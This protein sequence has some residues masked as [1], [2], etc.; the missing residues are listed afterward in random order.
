MCACPCSAAHPG[1]AGGCTGTASVLGGPG[2]EP[3][4][5]W[6]AAAV[7]GG[8][9]GAAAQQAVHVG[10][11]AEALK[12]DGTL[13]ASQL[14]ALEALWRSAHAAGVRAGRYGGL[15]ALTSP[16]PAAPESAEHASVPD[17]WRLLSA[18]AHAAAGIGPGRSFW[19]GWCGTAPRWP[20]R[21]SWSRRDGGVTVRLPG[22]RV[23]LPEGRAFWARALDGPAD[24]GSR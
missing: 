9:H 12:M 13:T 10:R 1:M 14:A 21:A 4:C 23:V 15:A 6:C 20:A 3:L 5:G 19:F 11:A 22:D 7:S 8:S 2:C 24:G 16:L 17:G 18:D